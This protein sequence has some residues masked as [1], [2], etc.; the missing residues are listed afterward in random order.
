MGM[1]KGPGHL[2]EGEVEDGEI[3]MADCVAHVCGFLELDKQ[4]VSHN[5]EQ[6]CLPN[7][8]K[9]TS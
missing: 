9:C 6:S 3:I 1:W 5:E 7:M 2:G 4:I 8:G